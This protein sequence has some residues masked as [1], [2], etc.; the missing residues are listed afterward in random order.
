VWLKLVFQWVSWH[1]NDGTTALPHWQVRLPWGCGIISAAV[2]GCMPGT[3]YFTTDASLGRSRT[4]SYVSY[5]WTADA[6]CTSRMAHHWG[7]AV[8]CVLGTIHTRL[9][10]G[11]RG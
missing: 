4:G 8:G 3:P 1:A 11:R 9:A 2:H 5:S 6:I 10:A 7:M